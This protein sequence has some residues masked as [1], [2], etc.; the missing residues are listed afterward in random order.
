MQEKL[1]R[2]GQIAR[3]LAVKEDAGD[4][5]DDRASHR[6]GEGDANSSDSVLST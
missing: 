6:H 2:P 4:A 5:I 1:D 3:L